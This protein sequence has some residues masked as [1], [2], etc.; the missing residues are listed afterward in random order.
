[1]A[2]TLNLTN[3]ADYFSDLSAAS[4]VVSINNQHIVAPTVTGQAV[5]V[6]ELMSGG[7]FRIVVLVLDRSPSMKPVARLLVDGFNNDFV[8]AINAARG[9]DISVLRIGGMSF[10]S[11]ITP[12]WG[13]GQTFF[14]ALDELPQ[15]TSREYYMGYGGTALHQALIDA[16]AFAM[17]YADELKT[18][19]GTVPDIDIICLS[20]GENN[21]NPI[22][23]DVVKV[24]ITGNRKDLVRFS[25]IY[26][27]TS[28]SSDP[29]QT[30]RRMLASA[31][32]M[33]FD[34]ENVQVFAQQPGETEQERQRRFR[35][36]MHVMSRVSASRG[37]SVTNAAAAVAQVADDDII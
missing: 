34:P 2:S 19:T 26:F 32:K 11:D 29:A 15:L 4:S 3:V 20:D 18:E 24:M 22:D 8:P 30:E 25:Y 28:G 12:I 33:G 21:E 5:T 17:K 31:K 14:H 27:D 7:G 16:L 36:M 23:P 9:D 6:E 1:M 35:R 10:S 37:T 13:N